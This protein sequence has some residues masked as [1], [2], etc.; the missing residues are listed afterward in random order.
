MYM[1]CIPR[2]GSAPS[3]SSFSSLSR[4]TSSSLTPFSSPSPSPSLST[5]S[6]TA[7]V[8]TPFSSCTSFPSLV[9]TFHC[10]PSQLSEDFSSMTVE[11]LKERLRSANL[12]VSGVK[13]VLIDRLVEHAKAQ[14]GGVDSEFIE[15]ISS[16]R[17]DE[18]SVPPL[19]ESED[20]ALPVSPPELSIESA[21]V[22]SEEAAEVTQYLTSLLQSEDLE[23]VLRV[24]Q[25][26]RSNGVQLP[27]SI[28]LKIT[29]ALVE[30]DDMEDAFEVYDTMM[31]DNEG[32]LSAGSNYDTS[33]FNL[34]IKGYVENGAI[35][36]VVQIEEALEYLGVPLLEETYSLL[37]NG[38]IKMRDLPKADVVFN[39]MILDPHVKVT[40]T[41]FESVILA[42][43]RRKQPSE[44]YAIIGKMSGQGLKP[45]VDLYHHVMKV[46]TN[47]LDYS[48]VLTCF[49]TMEDRQ[50]PLTTESWNYVLDSHCR[51]D[52]LERALKFFT[53]LAKDKKNQPDQFSY[54]VIVRK[55]VKDG[56]LI[57]A[58][59][60]FLKM[61]TVPLT[62]LPVT[63]RF[64]VEGMIRSRQV[65]KA[66]VLIDQMRRESIPF[67]SALMNI[68][69]K[70]C[71]RKGYLDLYEARFG[72]LPQHV[73]RDLEAS[74]QS[75][76]QSLDFWENDNIPKFNWNF[77]GD[78]L[79]VVTEA[80]GAREKYNN[81]YR[82]KLR[83][84]EEEFLVDVPED[85]LE[86]I[87]S[88][89]EEFMKEQ[90]EA[91]TLPDGPRKRK[92][93]L[94][95]A[96]PLKKNPKTRKFLSTYKDT[97]RPRAQFNFLHKAGRKG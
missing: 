37:I 72:V 59:K 47:Q 32:D 89:Q 76:A 88:G 1:R 19:E 49:Y 74:R 87:R 30:A 84:L 44:A 25:N 45:T 35:L 78:A 12:K 85:E 24:L 86:K 40:L 41:I 46:A 42:Y 61:R 48:L 70:H 9:R 3:P 5:S 43:T 94:Q 67:Q 65:K 8:S 52:L 71:V 96:N 6:T 36:N 93:K 31:K 2:L 97:R 29:E 95:P 56:R 69:K 10:S 4:F 14:Q 73:D 53:I 11:Q 57:E 77:E 82:E 58:E 18:A 81:E 79:S 39:K 66:F 17:P 62:G 28:Y 75:R 26:A 91:L 90:D 50:L 68:I 34:L 23:P 83:S 21:E 80:R 64:M 22:L 54:H 20:P 33:I 7:T 51:A 92:P 27:Y 13:K 15:P 60:L 16:T 38:Y 63:W 55:L